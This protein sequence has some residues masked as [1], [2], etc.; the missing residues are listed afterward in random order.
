[1]KREV[2][3][4]M[5]LRM[6]FASARRWL[7]GDHRD[8]GPIGT[9]SRVAVGLVAIVIP[10]TLSG[11]GGWE[12]AA[13]LIGFP[14]M[15]TA[16]AR[17]LIAG[18]ERYAP[19]ALAHPHTICSGPACWLIGLLVAIEFSLDAVTPVDGDVAFWVWIGA[20][21]LL[22]AAR[23]YGGCEVLA[24]PNALTG[25]RDQIGC[26]LYTPIDIAEARHRRRAR[27]LAVHQ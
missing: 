1:V 7:L 14:L 23:G 25:R 20:S 11:I 12:I 3:E 5:K 6:R 22:G 15:A 19:G 24:F 2:L 8:I 4:V 10:I 13:A 18:Y 27:P 17:L 21:M 9:A 26:I 16:V